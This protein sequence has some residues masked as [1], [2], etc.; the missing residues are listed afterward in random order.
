MFICSYTYVHILIIVHIYNYIYRIHFPRS[1]LGTGS[2]CD[3]STQRHP[4]LRMWRLLCQW[5]NHGLKWS[6]KNRLHM[7]VCIYILSTGKIWGK[8]CIFSRKYDYMHSLKITRITKMQW[9]CWCFSR[10]G[11]DHDPLKHHS[12]HWFWVSV[13]DYYFDLTW[14]FWMYIRAMDFV[15]II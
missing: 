12:L 4:Y 1:Y 9:L 2:G 14:V 11:V 10:L 3:P 6:A 8:V 15:W 5:Q 7:Y 13:V